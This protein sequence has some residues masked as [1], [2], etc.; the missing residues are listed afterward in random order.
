MRRSRV[1][2]GRPRAIAVAVMQRSHGS[3]SASRGICRKAA[4]TSR[5]DRLSPERG[6][7]V[8]KQ[9]YDLAQLIVGE[10]CAR[11]DDVPEVDGRSGAVLAEQ[12]DEWTEGRR[13]LGLDV[14]TRCRV[15]PVTDPAET[16]GEVTTQPIIPALSA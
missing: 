4:V 6:L 11:A 7:G 12:H 1:T 9:P 14:L 10:R 8:T 3:P 5:G 15:P 2:R 16:T 13:Y